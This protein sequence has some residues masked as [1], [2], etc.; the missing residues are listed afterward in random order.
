MLALSLEKLF[1]NGSIFTLWESYRT[2]VP[3][4]VSQCQRK[5]FPLALPL[6]S[7]VPKPVHLDA[8]CNVDLLLLL[9]LYLRFSPS[10]E[11]FF[12]SLFHTISLC[13]YNAYN[14]TLVKKLVDMEIS[15]RLHLADINASKL[16]KLL[17]WSFFLICH[18]PE[19][20]Q[21]FLGWLVWSVTPSSLAQVRVKKNVFPTFLARTGPWTLHC[22]SCVEALLGYV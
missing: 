20:A 9:L 22:T 19:T 13:M 4:S 2:G 17:Y 16:C 8:I 6:I 10:T 21:C 11:L 1:H 12:S 5:L 15:V 18:F 3:V 7:K 14:F